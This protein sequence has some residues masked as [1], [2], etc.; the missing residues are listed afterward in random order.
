AAGGGNGQAGR[1]GALQLHV[2]AGGLDGHSAGRGDTLQA[3][4]A[5][6]RHHFQALDVAVVQFRVAAGGADLHIPGGGAAQLHVTAG[7]VAGDLAAHRPVQVDVAADGGQAG[8][9][10]AQ[11]AGGLDVAAG[12][13]DGQGAV[14]AGGQ[15]DR[16]F[17]VVVLVVEQPLADAG[18]RTG[19][20]Q[21]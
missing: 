9:R 12:V 7:G 17:G 14:I 5:A 21:G 13:G 15:I 20:G 1:V 10:K 16:H 11:L 4:V 8:R 19:D 18:F 3:G 6:H 2:A